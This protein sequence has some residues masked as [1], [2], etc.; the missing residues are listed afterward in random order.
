MT[1]IGRLR[2]GSRLIAA[3]MCGITLKPFRRIYKDYGARFV[4]TQMVSAKALTMRDKKSFKILDFDESERPIGFQL[5]GHDP[6]VL[7]EGAAIAQD[8][9]PDLIDLNMG[10]PANKIVNDGGGAALLKEPLKVETI[11][12]GMRKVLKV[13]FTVK[14]RTGW[15]KDHDGAV[16]IARLAEDCGVE[17]VT[18]HARTKAQ[19]FKG[20][21]NW[22]LIRSL[23]EA[24]TIP[25]FGNG[26]VSSWQEANR[27][28]DE[29]GCDGV[30]VGRAAVSEPWI[31]R[32]FETQKETTP[33]SGELLNLLLR[34]YDL[35][36]DFFGIESGIKMMRKHLCAYTKG[37]REG[38]AFRGRALTIDQ[39]TPLR[40]LIENFFASDKRVLDPGPCLKPA[41]AGSGECPSVAGMTIGS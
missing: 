13:P 22:S 6:C 30:M 28:I 25:V 21:A 8:L 36:F 12:K 16:A 9:G 41:G 34:Q 1:T 20:E 19:G 15:D 23:K 29:T 18:L 31:F 3:P 40:E 14:M 2:I 35:Y 17:A 32:D 11:L 10:C 37:M 26:D 5:F 39:W 38:T 33:E 24:L 27:M 7:A 4:F